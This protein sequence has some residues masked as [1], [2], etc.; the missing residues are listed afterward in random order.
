MP[1]PKDSPPDTVRQRRRFLI[2]TGTSDYEHL[3]EEARLPSVEEDLARIRKLFCEALQYEN[4]LPHLRINPKREVFRKALGQWILKK[5]RSES[6][7]VVIYYS[8]HGDIEQDRHYL[9]TADSDP[10]DL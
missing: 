1:S 2:A 4:A 6:D 7:V 10:D 8:G 3:P 5:D 9:L